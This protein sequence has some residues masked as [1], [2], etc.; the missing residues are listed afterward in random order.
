[1]NAGL[2][3]IPP[4]GAGRKRQLRAFYLNGGTV[5]ANVIDHYNGGTGYLYFNGGVLQA[6]AS[7]ATFTPNTADNLYVDRA[8]PESTPHH[9]IGISNP[10]VPDPAIFVPDA[11]DR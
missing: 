8:V 7:T 5:Q 6:S 4:A 2:V 9:A 10:I 3:T 1:M 11:L